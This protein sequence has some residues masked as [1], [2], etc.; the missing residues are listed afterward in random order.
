MEIK[1]ISALLVAVLLLFHFYLTHTK[2][3]TKLQLKEAVIIIASCVAIISLGDLSLDVFYASDKY[4]GNFKDH[5]WTI[6]IGCFATIW[7][8]TESII[9]LFQPLFKED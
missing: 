2:K 3:K 8:S 5:Q 4:L 9:S 1:T 6:L 7:V